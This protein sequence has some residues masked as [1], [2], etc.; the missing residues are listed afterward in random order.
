V[1]PFLALTF[2]LATTVAASAQAPQPAPQQSPGERALAQ[3]LMGEIN[4]GLQCGTSL[5]AAQDQI[6]QL[7]KELA[8]EK[9]KTAPPVTP[10]K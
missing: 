6:A 9:A 8:D 4:N 2:A 10:K 5:I 1:K 3:R 7:Q